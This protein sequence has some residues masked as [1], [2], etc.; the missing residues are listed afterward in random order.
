MTY[1]K[2]NTSLDLYQHTHHIPPVKLVALCDSGGFITFNNEF[3]YLGTVISSDLRDCPDIYWRINQASKAFGSLRS[4]V[5]C[6]EKQLIPIIW[7]RLFMAIVM[8]LLLWGCT[9]PR[10]TNG[11]ATSLNYYTPASQQPAHS[12][13]TRS[14][15]PHQQQKVQLARPCQLIR[16]A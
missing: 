14:R 1:D 4:S 5:F 11:A 8:D 3:C 7:C 9:T 15:P 10:A 6:N 16:Q 13:T 12:T 2:H